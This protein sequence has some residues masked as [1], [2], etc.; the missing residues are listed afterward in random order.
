MRRT[1]SVRG[2][3]QVPKVTGGRK[4]CQFFVYASW[5]DRVLGDKE[6]SS[7]RSTS[8]L[9]RGEVAERRSSLRSPLC[10]SSKCLLAH[11]FILAREFWLI[12]HHETRPRNVRQIKTHTPTYTHMPLSPP[13]WPCREIQPA[14][15]DL[16]CPVV[17][18]YFYFVARSVCRGL[19]CVNLHPS[20]G[21]GFD[22]I[23]AGGVTLS[24]PFCE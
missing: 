1:D 21:P 13:A 2:L 15:R 8:V 22:V 12:V 16:D 9:P 7:S 17:Q 14:K 20:R 18:L 3:V 5:P 24:F 4:F 10:R 6:K 23:K 11:L 19:C